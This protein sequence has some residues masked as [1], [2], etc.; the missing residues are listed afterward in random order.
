MTPCG[1]I[2]IFPRQKASAKLLQNICLAAKIS[3]RKEA[4]LLQYIRRPKI[5]YPVAILLIKSGAVASRRVDE[6]DWRGFVHGIIN[7]NFSPWFQISS[8]PMN[9]GYDY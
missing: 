2:P 9:A 1:N 4:R 5:P 6:F 8:D 7:K 3:E